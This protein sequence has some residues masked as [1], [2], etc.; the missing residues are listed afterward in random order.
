MRLIYLL[1]FASIFGCQAP[2]VM[3]Y[4]RSVD[5]LVATIK[6]KNDSEKLLSVNA[7]VLEPSATASKTVYDLSP[8]GQAAIVEALNSKTKT[9]AELMSALASPI[10]ET[11]VPASIKGN[12][13]WKKRIVLNILK[14]DKELANRVQQILFTLDIPASLKEQ[15]SFIS[16]DKIATETQSIDLG[17]ITSGSTIGASFSPEITMAGKLQGVSAGS[18]SVS[19]TFNEEK[20]FTAKFAGLN[21]ALVSADKFQVYRQA[22]PN[23]NISGNIVVELTM[24]SKNAKE[25]TVY[26]F[27][28]L[29]SGSSVE[30]DQTKVVLERTLII[31]PDFGT[32]EE[33]PIN[34]SYSYRYRSIKQ[35][36]RT[37]PEYDDSIQ[38]TDVDVV[39]NDKF[40]IFDKEEVAG[41]T[42]WEIS[43]NGKTLHIYKAG[44]P[45]AEA[46]IFENFNDAQQFL[47]WI[48]LTKNLNVSDC[49]IYLGSAST[50]KAADI[51]DLSVLI[52][53]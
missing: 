15:V 20:S 34:L 49:L 8:E 51:K 27:K 2:R 41:P 5:P 37:E 44:N 38:Y 52:S 16:W 18:A 48:K 45:S 23:E 42:T 50:I 30:N 28:G 4:H 21:A 40:K 47:N 1:F 22:M 6:L 11:G 13:V 39:E 36:A 32:N 35:A 7:F 53:K 43:A 9:S 26:A 29:Y 12:K 24:K 17:K 33:V 14:T 31:R 19:K 10:K 25:Y 46:L 3:R